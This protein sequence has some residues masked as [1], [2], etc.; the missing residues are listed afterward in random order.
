[1]ST[2]TRV[3]TVA[4]YVAMFVAIAGGIFGMGLVQDRALKAHFGEVRC[5]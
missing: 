2:K 3:F 4:L 1:M 5:E